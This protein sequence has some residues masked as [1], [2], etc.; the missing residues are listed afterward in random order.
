ML[1]E[2]D[3]KEVQGPGQGALGGSGHGQLDGKH[4]N[5]LEGGFTFSLPYYKKHITLS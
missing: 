3:A 1:L 4:F 2:Q 5:M